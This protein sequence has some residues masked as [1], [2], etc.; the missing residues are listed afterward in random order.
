MALQ[1]L[2]YTSCEQGLSGFSGFQFNAVSPGVSAD[3]MHAVEALSGYEPPR[4]LLGSDTPEELARCPVKLCY[5]PSPDGDGGTAVCARY[6]GRDSARRF[7]NYFAHALHSPADFTE[8][9]GR[10]LPVELWDSPEWTTTAVA[11]NRIPELSGAPRPGPLTPDAAARFLAAHPYGDKL[12]DL[13]AAVFAALDEKRTVIVVDTS[14]ERIAHWF[15]AV[16]YLLPPPRARRL[17]FATYLH[18][19]GRSRLHLVGALP[20]TRID[21]GPDDHDSYR[22]FDFTSGHFPADG[23]VPVHHLVR[24]LARI[25]VAQAPSVWS[26][27]TGYVTGREHHLGDWHAPLAAAATA[28]G[29][30]LEADDVRALTGWIGGASHLDE[31]QAAVARDVF[32]RHRDLDETQLQALSTAA[33]DGGDHD[34]HQELEGRLFESRI[35]AYRD[36]ASNAVVPVPFADAEQLRRAGAYWQQVLP[37]ADPRQTARLL[38]WSLG[39]ELDPPRE[40]FREAA[41]RLALSLLETAALRSADTRA[42]GEIRQLYETS[43]AFRAALAH[44]VAELLDR[45]PGQAMVFFTFPASL[46]RADDLRDM[47][48]LLEH[49]WVAQTERSPRLAVEHLGRILRLRGKDVPDPELLQRLWPRRRWTHQEAIEIVRRLPRSGDG[50]KELGEWFDRAVG[51]ETPDEASLL[52]AL[53]LCHALSLPGR[54]GWLLPA[55]RECVQTCL[56]LADRLET[57]ATASSLAESFGGSRIDKW[58]PSQAL[59]KLR[60]PGR[61]VALPVAPPDVSRY[62]LRMGDGTAVAYLTKLRAAAASRQG[63]SDVVLGHVGGLLLM[64]AE[65]RKVPVGQADLVMEITGRA[66]TAWRRKDAERLIAV[67]RPYDREYAQRLQTALDERKSLASRLVPRRRNKDKGDR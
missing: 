42:Q 15:A 30:P 44:A 64:R 8:D 18:Q 10:L 39:S 21:I 40:V 20:E 33:R 2:Y 6:V 28:G 26:W 54:D 57:S 36:D 34:L 23:T 11:E 25:G 66:V 24:L 7:G 19:P 27:A 31:L 50:G 52:E 48:L 51:Q 67:V 16:S 45:R 46:L 32:L 53:A 4:S 63:V 58:G 1:Q 55:T 43:P 12:A 56:V 65:R 17:S 37:E 47:P 61:L 60:L 5:V 29:V 14:T 62:L 49:Y 3:T 9:S 22:V 41:D 13:L 35:R 38:L 59:K